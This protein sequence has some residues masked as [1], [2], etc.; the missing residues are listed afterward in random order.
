M[1]KVATKP[2]DAADY[3]ETSEDIA[4]FLQDAVESGDAGVIAAALGVV[5]R[6]RGASAMAAASGVSRSALYKS[7]A[8]GGNPT[9]AVVLAILGELGL[10]M[11][12]TPA[13]KVP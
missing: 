1:V 7:L 10:K 9:L 8:D 4:L 5:A 2:F 6:S 3:L 11:E 13:K 12:I